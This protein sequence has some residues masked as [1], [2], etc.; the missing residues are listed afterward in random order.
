MLLAAL[1]CFTRHGVEATAIDMIREASGASVGSLYHHFGNKEGIAAEVYKEG[2]RDFRA[3]LAEALTDVDSLAG[4]ARSIVLANV[5][6]ISANPDW[7]R[8]IFNYR[9]APARAEGDADL[10]A[11]TQA[12][13]EALQRQLL[14]LLAPGQT[15]AWSPDICQAVIIGPVHYYARQWLDGRRDVSL[16]DMREVFAEA[17]ARSVAAAIRA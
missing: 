1:Q 10:Q 6:W 9:M 5:D 15:L 2:L 14:R 16:S 12:A 11:E 3:C 4:A 17:A 8:F 13:Q 7:A